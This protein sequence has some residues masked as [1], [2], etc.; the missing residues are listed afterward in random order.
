MVLLMG[1]TRHVQVVQA[2]LVALVVRVLE[3]DDLRE[4]AE[5]RFDIGFE[6]INFVGLWIIL[7]P[8]I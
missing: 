8:E 3:L 6:L 2:V 5:Y 4:K 1:E 7:V